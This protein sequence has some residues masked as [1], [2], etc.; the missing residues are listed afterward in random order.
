M[1]ASEVN[2]YL[3]WDCCYFEEEINYYSSRN[4]TLTRLFFHLETELGLTPIF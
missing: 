4:Y 3:A 1:M 2:L